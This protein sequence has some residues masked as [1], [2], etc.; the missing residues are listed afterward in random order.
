MTLLSVWS[1][2]AF[3]CHHNTGLGVFVWCE[4][5]VTSLSLPVVEIRGDLKSWLT[6]IP[7]SAHF[8]KNAHI[9]ASVFS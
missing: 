5:L 8:R 2:K 9:G 7:D 6:S 4:T 3:S 1:G